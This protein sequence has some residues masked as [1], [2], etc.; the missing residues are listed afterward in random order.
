VSISSLFSSYEKQYF[1]NC[2][3]E[4]KN[5]QKLDGSK[6]ELNLSYF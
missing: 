4:P 2:G 6:D 1:P 3:L 5:P